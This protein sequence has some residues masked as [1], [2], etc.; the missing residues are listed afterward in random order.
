[1]FRRPSLIFSRLLPLS[2]GVNRPKQRIQRRM[3]IVTLASN[4]RVTLC[5]NQ[6]SNSSI[7]LHVRLCQMKIKLSTLALKPRGD[8]SRSP[9]EGYDSVAP[10]KRTC[11]HK[12]FF[13]ISS[14]SATAFPA[15]YWTA[16]EFC[17][18]LPEVY[19]MKLFGLKC[20]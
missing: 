12:I 17:N 7:F 11:V 14:A 13:S 16:S 6:E 20:S 8:G 5:S 10:Q 19:F 3:S 15:D 1:M 9:K 4:Q 18:F 2:L